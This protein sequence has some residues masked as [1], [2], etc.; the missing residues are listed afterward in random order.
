MMRFDQEIYSKQMNQPEDRAGRVRSPNHA[1]RVSERG[2][3]ND[4]P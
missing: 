4:N 1:L 3:R 2:E